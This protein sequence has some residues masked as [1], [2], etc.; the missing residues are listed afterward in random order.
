MI[1]ID[2]EAESFKASQE[3]RRKPLPYPMTEAEK[4][5]YD[6]SDYEDMHSECKNKDDEP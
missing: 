4:R 5:S 1:N 6:Y 3:Q 2:N